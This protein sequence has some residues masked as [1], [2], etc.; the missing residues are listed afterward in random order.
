[1]HAAISLSDQ[2]I[3]LRAD[4]LRYAKLQLR[5]DAWAEDAVSDTLLVAL[6]QPESFDGRSQLKTWLIGI[7]KFKIL[8][9]FRANAREV[10]LPESEDV[11]SDSDALEGLLF[12]ADGHYATPLNEW[13]DPVSQLNRQEFFVILE[14]CMDKLPAQL[15]RLFM[16]REWLEL[17]CEDICKEL[18]LTS[19]N[20]YVQMHRARLRLRECLDL[21]WYGNQ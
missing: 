4:L 17:S 19:T 18:K 6:E 11:N 7:L 16:M 5:N 2:L 9:K 1:M 13:T 3:P 21:N 8:D 20:F 14:T 12:K 10:A 15:S